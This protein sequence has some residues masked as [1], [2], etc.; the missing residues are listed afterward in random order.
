MGLTAQQVIDLLG[1][2][3][4]P[5]CGFVAETFRSQQRIPQPALPAMY[6]GGRPFGSVLYSMVTRPRRRFACIAFAQTRCITTTSAIRSRCWS[7]IRT[8]AAPSKWLAPT[9]QPERVPSCSSQ[10]APSTCR[11]C[12]REVATRLGTT[13]WPGVEPPDVELGDRDHL[14]ATHPAF[15]DEIIDFIK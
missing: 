15:R 4:H 6:E 14:I 10:A 1:L 8:G 7:C 3:P 11:G 5:T 13:E 2:K 9:W 12:A